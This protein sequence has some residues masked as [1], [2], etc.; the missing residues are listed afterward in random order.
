MGRF[1]RYLLYQFTLLFGFFS[2]VL[3]A[4]YW[5][6]RAVI[7]FEQ[8]I[9][10]GES[11]LVF[12]EFILLTLPNVVRLVLPIS[13]FTAVVY[14]VNRL[15]SESELVV[16]QATGYS[17]WRLVRPAVI[18]G[19][20]VA[21]IVLIFTHYLV[22]VSTDRLNAKTEQISQNVT[23]RLL[24]EGRF[25]HPVQG[26][27]LYVREI[28]PSGELQDI[29]VSDARSD[30]SR[31]EYM[32]RRAL[33]VRSSS[34]PSLLMFDGEAQTLDRRT[35]KLAVTSF[36]EFAYDITGLIS[37]TPAGLRDPDTV[38]T[39]DLIFADEALEQ[40]TGR[41]RAQLL[42][43]GHNRI[44]QALLAMVAPIIGMAVLMMGSFSRF[45]MWRQIGGAVVSLILIKSIDNATVQPA[46]ADPDLWALPYIAPAAGALLAATCLYLAAKPK[47]RWGGAGL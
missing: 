46:R 15:S 29:Y 39:L 3:V 26:L 47:R 17:P 8:L 10:N 24:T 9:A 37:A 45:G 4:V 5:V 2:L 32:A 7:L 6:N 21:L 14:A 36:T 18:F 44:T 25:I 23:A 16:V 30:T 42:Y 43:E 38:N 1:D 31:T 13:A 22:P 33:L 20:L 28:S 40:A 34:G 41:T 11:A 12:L 27:T 19:A 35:R